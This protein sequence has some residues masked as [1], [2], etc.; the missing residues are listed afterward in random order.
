MSCQEHYG[1]LLVGRPDTAGCAQGL[2]MEN[3]TF[4][5]CTVAFSNGVGGSVAIFDTS[6]DITDC[7]FESSQGTAVLFES[8]SADGDHLL[9]VSWAS[10]HSLYRPAHASMIHMSDYVGRV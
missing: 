7:T 1:A 5:G 2:F 9:S 6:A 3:S 8:S 10:R 4:T